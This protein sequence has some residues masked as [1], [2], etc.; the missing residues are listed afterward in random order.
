MNY[1]DKSGNQEK[2][3]TMAVFHTSWGTVLLR[4]LTEKFEKGTALVNKGKVLSSPRL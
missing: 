3:Q 2:C 1:S 4:S